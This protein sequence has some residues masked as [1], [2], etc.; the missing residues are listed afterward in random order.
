[1]QIDMHYYGTFAM[2]YAAG[3]GVGDAHVVATS[4]QLVDDN[5]LTTLHTLSSRQG[6][7]GV[8]TAHHPLDAGSRVV[9]GGDKDDSRL[10]WV[11]RSTSCLAGRASRSMSASSASRTATSLA[12]WSNTTR[13][14]PRSTSTEATACS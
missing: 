7:L 6:V 3:L 1:M 13:L 2:A 8:A 5:N 14:R 12:K 9:H 10:I 11:P 4:A